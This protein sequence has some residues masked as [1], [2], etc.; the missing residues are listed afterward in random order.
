MRR[1]VVLSILLSGISA[2]SLAQSVFT[3]RD[4]DHQYNMEISAP[5]SISI[6]G[7]VDDQSHPIL[8][9]GGGFVHIK[10]WIGGQSA[11]QISAAQ[12]VQVFGVKDR[13]SLT[14]LSATDAFVER[15]IEGRSAVS[16]AAK[17]NVIIARVID[18]QSKVDVQGASLTVAEKIGGRSSLTAKTTGN[19]ILGGVVEG[20]A[21]LTLTT[22]GTIT[23]RR[24]FGSDTVVFYCAPAAPVVDEVK[25]LPTVRKLDLCPY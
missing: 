17:G 10:D 24:L 8:R 11:V 18:G 1:I 13:S 2:V 21:T 14:V 23:I 15:N 19:I 6:L 22:P 9:S 12:D 4:L 20:G 7:G 3:T 25:D 16:I 5:E